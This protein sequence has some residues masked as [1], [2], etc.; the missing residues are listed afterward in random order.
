M[1]KASA[2]GASRYGCFVEWPGCR[3]R[4]IT[5]PSPPALARQV[6]RD[7]QTALCAR[8]RLNRQGPEYADL[9]SLLDDEPPPAWPAARGCIGGEVEASLPSCVPLLDSDVDVAPVGRAS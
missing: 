3:F 1:V 6:R 7:P 5:A 9:L 4:A 2:A 8:R